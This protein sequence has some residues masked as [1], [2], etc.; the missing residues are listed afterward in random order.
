MARMFVTDSARRMRDMEAVDV[1][2]CVYPNGYRAE[3]LSD[4][5]LAIYHG[6]IEA[7]TDRASHVLAADS[8]KLI[9]IQKRNTE[10]RLAVAK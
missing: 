5:S 3:R 4:G 7:T 2:V 8:V 9:A 6:D 10:R 1:P